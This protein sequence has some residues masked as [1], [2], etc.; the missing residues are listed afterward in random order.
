MYRGEP[1]DGIEFY[2]LLNKSE[3][4]TSELGKVGLASGKLEAELILFLKRKDIKGKY[5]KATLGTLIDLAEK[6]D[7]IDENMRIS[8]KMI[9]KQRNYITHNIYGL[10]IDLKDETILEKENLLD[11]DVTL[12]IDRV[13]QLKENLDG[14]AD[15][16]K[17]KK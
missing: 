15:I 7:L 1:S 4:F 8:L 12:Y 3:E 10:F 9:S 2:N 16:V 14:L 11:T 6:N 17:N 13:W 5:D